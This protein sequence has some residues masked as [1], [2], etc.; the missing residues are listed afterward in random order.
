MNLVS[1]VLVYTETMTSVAFR[2]TR[3]ALENF[4]KKSSA[5]YS[6]NNGSILG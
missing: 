3:A 5:N 6:K 2:T 1:K 4:F